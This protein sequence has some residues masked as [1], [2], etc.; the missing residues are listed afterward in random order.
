M[1]R[2]GHTFTSGFLTVV[3][4][5][6]LLQGLSKAVLWVA[7]ARAAGRIAFQESVVSSRGATW[8]RYQFTAPDGQLYAGSAMTAAKGAVNTRVQ[9]AYLPLAPT[10][11]MPAYGGYTTLMGLAWGLTGLVLVGVAR[12]FRRPD[13]QGPRRKKPAGKR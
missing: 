2:K 1:R 7:G 3:G 5:L 12:L 8:V 11:N 6:C 9:V 4:T 10:V 13:S